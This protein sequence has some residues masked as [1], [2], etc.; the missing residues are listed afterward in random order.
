M[1]KDK[2][3]ITKIGGKYGNLPL[4]IDLIDEL[5]NWKASYELTWSDPSPN[6][7]GYRMTM[8]Q[9]IRR[10]LEG[11]KRLDPDVW[12]TH[13]AAAKAREKHAAVMEEFRQLYTEEL[14]DAK[15]KL[16]AIFDGEAESWTPNPEGCYYLRGEERLDVTDFGT[17]DNPILTVVDGQEKGYEEMIAEGWELF[18]GDGHKIASKEMIEALIIESCKPDT[19]RF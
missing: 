6:G 12:V 5:R 16:D 14:R 11:V 2:K 4:P 8:E 9:L 13:Q 15:K 17:F 3:K 10:L 1:P 19:W 18:D 7:K